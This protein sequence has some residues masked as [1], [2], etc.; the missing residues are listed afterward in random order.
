MQK[1][2]EEHK[3]RITVHPLPSY[4][5]DYNPIEKLWKEIKKDGTHLHYFPTFDALVNKVDEILMGFEY[6]LEKVLALF[7]MYYELTESMK[8]VP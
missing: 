8:E 7:G 6:K 2:F 4:S 5:P 3:E 1:F